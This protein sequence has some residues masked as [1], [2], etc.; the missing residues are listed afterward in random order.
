MVGCGR[1]HPPLRA[2]HKGGGGG[3]AWCAIP[4]HRSSLSLPPPPP[5]PLHTHLLDTA[6]AARMRGRVVPV[7]RRRR[8][9]GGG[10]S[11]SIW[12]LP[13]SWVP[14]VEACRLLTCSEPPGCTP[15]S[16]LEVR[17]YCVC[18]VCVCGG[19]GGRG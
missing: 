9:A 13:A 12:K 18:G 15:D 11:I 4:H 5:P 14:S 8:A 1:P 10:E 16:D 3:G 7:S 6:P 2:P 17:E 19:G